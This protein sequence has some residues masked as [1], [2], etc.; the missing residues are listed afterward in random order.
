MHPIIEIGRERHSD[1]LRLVIGEID[2]RG[3]VVDP[4]SGQRTAIER[5][6]DQS[7][8]RTAT[9]IDH[10]SG[11][12]ERDGR[13]RADLAGCLENPAIEMLIVPG[14]AIS[15]RPAIHRHESGGRDR[16]YPLIRKRRHRLEGNGGGPIFV[17]QRA[18]LIAGAC[19]LR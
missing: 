8:I 7:G 17:E 5:C 19:L 18:A 14:S 6:P 2:R 1:I 10:D 11:T 3:A 4:P 16:A 15:H 13:R 12:L 9:Q